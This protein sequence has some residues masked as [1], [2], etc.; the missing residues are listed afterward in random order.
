LVPTLQGYQVV[1]TDDI[2]ALGG[3]VEKARAA[4]TGAAATL[5]FLKTHC[6][7]D[8]ASYML[9]KAPD[10]QEVCLYE[11][12]AHPDSAAAEPASSDQTVPTPAEAAG[13]GSEADELASAAAAL[14]DELE[15]SEEGAPHVRRSPYAY[16]VAV[17]CYRMAAKMYEPEGARPGLAAQVGLRAARVGTGRVDL[18]AG[19][20]YGLQ[21]LRTAPPPR[22]ASF[23]ESPTPS[24][25]QEP[26]E[27]CRKLLQRCVDLCVA[28]SHPQVHAAARLRL[29]D[30]L[31]E[32]V[33]R[34]PPRRVSS[35]VTLRRSSSAA[36]ATP[37]VAVD[38]S[39]AGSDHTAAEL[40]C[41]EAAAHLV[42]G[43]RALESAASGS[44]LPVWSALKERLAQ[45]RRA[46]GVEG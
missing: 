13:V 33:P 44:C 11:L 7:T 6:V 42:A 35:A 34:A 15:V 2:P 45:V 21:E 41:G 25:F 20:G 40:R 14:V 26:R 4:L 32:E 8:G 43:L 39:K 29:A 12:F 18:R 46:R 36:D 10:A 28:A 31:L 9:H 23:P 5:R 37:A 16:H 30:L 19:R 24:L 1:K 38:C 17:L 27:R 22:H 3:A